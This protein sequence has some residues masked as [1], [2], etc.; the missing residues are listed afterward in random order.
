MSKP[1]L[2]TLP[3]VLLLLD[4]WPLGRFN[5]ANAGGA[6]SWAWAKRGLLLGA[7]KLPLVG[8]SA[9]ASAV[10]LAAQASMGATGMLAGELSWPLRASNAIVAYAAYLGKTIWPDRLAVFYPYTM[11]L[12][13]VQIAGCAALLV[14]LTIA[15]VLLARKAPY[16]PVGWF[17]YL[18]MLVPTIGLVQ[19]GGQSMADRYTYL[20]LIG[21]FWAGVWGIGDL[22]NQRPLAQGSRWARGCRPGRLPGGD[23]WAAKSLGQQ[24][25]VVSPRDCSDRAKSGRSSRFGR[26]PLESRPNCRGGRRISP[27]AAA[28]PQTLQEHA[29]HFGRALAETRPH[30]RGRRLPAGGDQCEPRQRPGAAR[31]GHVAGPAR[32][33]R[34]SHR[35]TPGGNSPG[36]ELCPRHGKIWPGSMPLA[37]TGISATAPRRSRLPGGPGN[38]QT[39]RI[40]SVSARWP[41]PT[42]RRTTCPVP[43]SNSRSPWT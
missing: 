5:V 43:K 38:S 41:T 29:D 27:G 2:V 16:L 34:R 23:Q 40:R 12:P 9:A 26:G 6:N 19:V 13:A 33:G 37:P 7:E 11:D 39:A 25:D 14:G 15:A 24:R 3:L 8:L 10:T 1:M 22:V 21:V 42:S 4:Y 35:A 18:G 20:P 30:G 32:T 17:W 31:S 36:P 28:R